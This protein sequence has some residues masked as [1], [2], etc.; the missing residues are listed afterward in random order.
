MT[1]EQASFRRSQRHPL[2]KTLEAMR[3]ATCLSQRQV[4]QMLWGARSPRQHRGAK[5]SWARIERGGGWLLA[6]DLVAIHRVIGELATRG[7]QRPQVDKPHV[8]HESPWDFAG[9]LRPW[10]T[11]DSITRLTPWRGAPAPFQ[12][13]PSPFQGPDGAL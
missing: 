11:V 7:I 6:G 13:R 2:V 5:S 8:W 4:A 12:G 3:R 9:P 10:G 1:T